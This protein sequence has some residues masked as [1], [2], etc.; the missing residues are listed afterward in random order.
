MLLPRQQAQAE[1]WRLFI[2]SGS[3]TWL[4]RP[5][6]ASYTS[7]TNV[8]TIHPL[9]GKQ[10][11]W[12]LHQRTVV[13]AGPTRSPRNRSTNGLSLEHPD[14]CEGQCWEVRS[15]LDFDVT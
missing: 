4:R 7:T 11:P 2:V 13:L 5:R 1:A 12:L 9:V 15:T 6:L 8:E 10:P 14:R 3:L